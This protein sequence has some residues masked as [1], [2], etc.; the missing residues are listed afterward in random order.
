MSSQGP[1]KKEGEG[2]RQR[3]EDVLLAVRMEG[4]A[5]IQ[6]GGTSRAWERQELVLPWSLWRDWPC[7]CLDLA[8]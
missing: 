8:P 4:G 7:P 6:G 3:D 5:T 1:Y 2:Q